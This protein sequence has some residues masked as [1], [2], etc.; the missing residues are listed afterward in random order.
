MRHH[1]QTNV[2]IMGVPVVRRKTGK[3]RSSFKD[4][5]ADN[6]QNLR[7]EMDIEIHEAHM[8][9]HKIKTRT[10]TTIY[11]IIKVS[12]VIDGI[13]KAVREKWLVIKEYK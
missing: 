10:P 11:A 2:H 8:I 1:K 9:P 12:R 5:L 13:L 4:I 6:F 7:K 3:E